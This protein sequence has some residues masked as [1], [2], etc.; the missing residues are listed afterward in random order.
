MPVT[1]YTIF[2]SDL[3]NTFKDEL[4]NMLSSPVVDDD[5]VEVE[6]SKVLRCLK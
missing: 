5:I 6:F 2:I 4:Q 1:N 3:T